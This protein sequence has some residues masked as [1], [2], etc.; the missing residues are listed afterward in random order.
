VIRS[1]Q[2]SQ[3]NSSIWARAAGHAPSLVRTLDDS[4]GEGTTASV[5]LTLGGPGA[6]VTGRVLDA[7]AQPVEGALVLVDGQDMLHAY[8]QT[9]PDGRK[10]VLSHSGPTS[11]RTDADGRFSVA[12]VMPGSVP[13]GVLAPGFAA[14]RGSI[15]V[16]AGESGEREITLS[17]G[18]RLSGT[19]RDAAG[20]PVA[21][22][23]FVFCAALSS[24]LCPTVMTGPDGGYE[25]EALAPGEIHVV[26]DG[27]AGDAHTI[28]SGQAGDDLSWDAL[29][30]AETSP[31]ETPMESAPWGR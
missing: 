15:S 26:V 31:G 8:P 19:V 5:T 14:W 2:G 4:E 25:F 29:L 1:L 11:T 20:N 16:A 21:G 17:S 23:V 9:L 18:F 7:D 28:L 24:Q 6:T 3:A 10:I 13:L 30:G 27:Q 12:G 22:R